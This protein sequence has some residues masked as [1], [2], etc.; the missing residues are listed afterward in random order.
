MSRIK[1][2]LWKDTEVNNDTF[3]NL[4]PFSVGVFGIFVACAFMFGIPPFCQYTEVNNYKFFI[5]AI[6]CLMVIG[7]MSWN[8]F[9]QAD[10]KLR[11]PG[12]KAKA[13]PVEEE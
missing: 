2:S 8:F 7:W 1:N 4:R 10:I 11:T 12:F 6:W 9:Y 5:V 13:E 3:K